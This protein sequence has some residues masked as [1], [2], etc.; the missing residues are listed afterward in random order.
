MLRKILAYSLLIIHLAFIAVSG[1]PGILFM[2]GCGS[3]NQTREDLPLF[4]GNSP[5]TGDIAFLRALIERAKEKDEKDQKPV[6]PERPNAQ[7]VLYY[8][9][10]N[11]YSNLI[12]HSISW[13][14]VPFTGDIFSRFLRIPS[15][16]PRFF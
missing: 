1:L 16:P 2:I 8:I 14:F 10:S 12:L 3:Q 5:L 15:P 13:K 6:M 9:Q 11:L 4:S 7:P